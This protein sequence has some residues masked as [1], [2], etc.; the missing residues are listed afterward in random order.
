MNTL[1]AHLREMLYAMDEQVKMPRTR[2]HGGTWLEYDRV[3][4]TMCAAGAWYAQHYGRRNIIDLSDYTGHIADTM[5]IMDFLR[6]F[7]IYE[8]YRRLYRREMEMKVPIEILKGNALRM[9]ADWRASMDALL[10]WLT[11]QNL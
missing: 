8:A 1:K 10:I 9:D 11:E 6:L 5:R 7:E 2:L 4:C 3:S